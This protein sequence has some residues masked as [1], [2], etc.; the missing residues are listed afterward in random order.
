MVGL[1]GSFSFKKPTK[2]SATYESN[3][4]YK[5]QKENPFQEDD[6]YLQQLQSIQ[7]TMKTIKEM[8]KQSNHS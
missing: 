8:D 5:F 4:S 1:F 2:L 3:L 6:E 7:D